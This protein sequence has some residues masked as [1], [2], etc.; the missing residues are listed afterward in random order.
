MYSCMSVA[1]NLCSC[2]WPHSVPFLSISC[3]VESLYLIF[4]LATK[5]PVCSHDVTGCP[6]IHLYS[7][8]TVTNLSMF[9]FPCG[10]HVISLCYSVTSCLL[11]QFLPWYH[12]RDANTLHKFVYRVF[13]VEGFV[14]LKMPKRMSS[15]AFLW[16]YG[17][18]SVIWFVD[19][20]LPYVKCICNL[21]RCLQLTTA[22]ASFSETFC[23]GYCDCRQ[24]PKT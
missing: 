16:L 17:T 8:S 6:S 21:C 11:L 5:C 13:A 24:S 14:A 3:F 12:S 4:Y 23:L 9:H 1:S 18:I 19:M 22:T 7:S 10:I 2:I 20:R 15:E